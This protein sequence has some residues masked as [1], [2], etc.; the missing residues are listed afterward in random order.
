MSTMV[1]AAL[2]WLLLHVLVAGP[3]RGVLVARLGEPAYRGL[4]SLLSVA[5]LAGLI[6]AYRAAPY[7]E[8]WAPSE[9]LN[10]VPL[11]VMPF[12]ILLVLG[13]LRTTNPTLAGPDMM[14]EGNLPVEGFTRI[15]R[16][17]MLW[18]FSL[19]AASHLI[20]NGDLATLLLAGSVLLT[21]LNGMR[22]ID[23][24]RAAKFGQAWEAFAA[25]TSV[26]PFAAALQG[27][28]QVG[29]RDIGAL[30]VMGALA[31]YLVGIWVHAALGKPVI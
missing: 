11:I 3:A 12:A 20:A 9:A 2:S 17:P 6:L 26:L 8:L 7:I 1:F 23:A 28:Q 21:A 22:S 10:L 14:L 30:N 19:W 24:K 25:R 27:R 5:A 16:H 31:I 15:T 4:F 18:G 29:L 13:G